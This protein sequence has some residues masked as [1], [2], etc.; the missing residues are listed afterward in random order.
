[1]SPPESMVNADIA[2]V[3]T[4][5]IGSTKF[6][7]RHGAQMAASW[8]GMHDRLVMSLITKNNGQWVDNSDGHLIYFASVEDA[9][10]FAFEYKKKLRM[11]KFPFKS[12]VGVH[13]DSMIIT[14]TAQHLVQG[15]VKRVNI[16]GLGKAIAARCMSLCGPE[17]ILMTHKAQLKFK[18]RKTNNRFIPKDALIALVGLY[19]FKG[20]AEP[21]SIYAIG[22]L[23]FQ[24]QPPPDSEKAKRLG[25]AKKIK[26]RLKHKRWSEIFFY[27]VWR[28]GILSVLAWLWVLWPL[29]S[30]EWHKKMWNI[31]YWWLEPFEWINYVLVAIGENVK[32]FF[33]ELNKGGK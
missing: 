23:E 26:T 6:V 32:W 11:H 21:E 24:L 29:L 27:F 20:V 1:M 10:A 8:F 13:W 28:I 31:D 25:G 2:I 30:S 22:Q 17:Q 19:K 18:S 4:D 9:V 14:K 3:L 12:R 16:E 15:G 5:I 7:Q 33:E